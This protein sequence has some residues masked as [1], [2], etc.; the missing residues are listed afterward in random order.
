MPTPTDTTDWTA[1]AVPSALTPERLAALVDRSLDAV[2][3]ML[4]TATAREDLDDIGRWQQLKDQAFAGQLRAIVAAYNRASSQHRFFAGDE[5]GLA[6][7]ATPTT[8][9]VL[10]TF[11]CQVTELPGLLEAV[12]AGMITERHVRAV[13]AELDKVTGLSLEQRQA[14]VLVMLARFDSHTP[15]ELA[16]LVRRLI[17]TVDRAAAQTRQDTATRSRRVQVFDDVDGQGVLHARGPVALIAAIKERLRAE[18]HGMSVDGEDARSTEQRELDLF[19]D[20]LT[21]GTLDDQPVAPY[22]VQVIV[23]FSTA[24]GGDLELA[25]IA[26]YGPI[27]PSTARDLLTQS[28]SM[29]QVAVNEDGAVIA[30]SDSVPGPAATGAGAYP[31]DLPTAV[32]PEDAG[33]GVD[34]VDGVDGVEVVD[35]VLAAIKAMRTPPVLRPL[36]TGAYRPS[37]RLSLF[38]AV[39]DR[40]CV[41]PGCHRRVTDKDHRI[42]WPLGPTDPENLQN[43]CRHHHR[44]KQAA[45]TVDLTTDGDYRWTTRGGWQFLRKRQGY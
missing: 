14:I 21:R 15:G 38:I 4:F 30:V 1:R 31:N 22:A 23:P 19:V 33:N 18:L 37:A 9:G 42:P 41:F 39:R 25:E 35:E 11:A 20:L 5:V 36:A 12:E 44:A 6:I 40:T 43:L 10:V 7:G 24:T 8:G 16:R 29:T 28:A 2:E 3:G 27:L 34:G 32:D 45:F 26:G 17:V 13:I